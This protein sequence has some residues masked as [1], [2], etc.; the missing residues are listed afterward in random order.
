MW[1]LARTVLLYYEIVVVD[2]YVAAE[3]ESDLRDPSAPYKTEFEMQFGGCFVA[4]CDN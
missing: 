2:R 3:F 1:D 4:R